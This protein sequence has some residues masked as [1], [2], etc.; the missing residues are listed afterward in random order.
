MKPFLKT[1]IVGSILTLGV[2]AVVYLGT[3][4][5]R[6]FNSNGDSMEVQR[7]EVFELIESFCSNNGWRKEDIPLVHSATLAGVSGSEV[8]PDCEQDVFEFTLD[9]EYLAVFVYHQ[10]GVA[11]SAHTAF[12]GGYSPS[13]NKLFEALRAVVPT[14]SKGGAAMV[15]WL[16]EQDITPDR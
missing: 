9:G 16:G 4:S 1:T 14:S 10:D 3:S 2:I 13:A 15:S 11:L 12:F 5:S 7:A 6:H 8:P